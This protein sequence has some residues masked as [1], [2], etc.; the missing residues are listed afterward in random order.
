MIQIQERDKKILKICY[1]QKC[2]SSEQVLEGIFRGVHRSEGYRRIQELEQAGFL[3]RI[4]PLGFGKQTVIQLT[5]LGE[6][7]ARAESPYDVPR[8][9]RL[10][11]NTLVHDL[12]VNRVRMRLEELWDGQWVPEVELK[13]T[14]SSA[15]EPQQIPD[16]I[17][18]WP[19]A[20]A[21]AIEVENSLK[22]L[23]RYRQI[24]R[25]YD[26]DDEIICLLYVAAT[27]AIYRG[28]KAHIQ[29]TASRHSLE[30]PVVLASLTELLTCPP[31]GV[32]SPRGQLALLQR[33]SF[34]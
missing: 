32:W 2:L 25:A 34:K 3:K 31:P 10:N 8:L 23:D 20:K 33:R 22:T 19:S 13:R 27:D 18:V 5:A 7:L 4:R 24:I 6:G 9:R 21:I 11:L 17:F 29:A 1:E 30:T 15:F 14:R 28:L 16:G 26:K 12:L